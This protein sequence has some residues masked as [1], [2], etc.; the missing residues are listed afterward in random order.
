MSLDGRLAAIDFKWNT[1]IGQEVGTIFAYRRAQVY[2]TV[3][4][5]AVAL[6][7]PMLGE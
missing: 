3:L 4:L 6:L 7:L 1:K 2:E 5:G